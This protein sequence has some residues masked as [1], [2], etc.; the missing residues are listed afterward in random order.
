MIKYV[1]NIHTI[2]DFHLGKV[3][4]SRKK[5]MSGFV[6]SMLKNRSVKF[7]DIASDLNESAQESS[8][9]RRIQ[10]FFADFEMD[11]LLYARMLMQ[12]VPMRRVAISI[13]RTNWKFGDTDINI[14][15]LT[16][17]YQGVGI[18]ILF[19]LLD[20]KGN[21]NSD[22]RCELMDKFVA[23]F[24]A[25]RICS[26]TAD[27]EF[28]GDMWFDY[29]IDKKIPFFLRLKKSHRLTLGGIHYRIDDIINSYVKKGEKYLRNITLHGR[30]PLSIGLRKLL[31]NGKNRQEDDYL[32]I[33]TNDLE[34]NALQEYKKRWS[35]ETFFQSI[36]E[37]GF[38]MEQ[39]HLKEPERL[40][41][42]FAF[43]ALGFV[44][45]VTIGVH[46][47]ESVKEIEVKNHGYK[48]NSFFRVGLDKFRKA[49][50]HVFD[51]ISIINRLITI[52]FKQIEKYFLITF[53][54]K[55]IIT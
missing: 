44:L 35:I 13:D 55:K 4:L 27:R 38:D 32:A 49:L 46:H 23:L 21:S 30:Y 5:F 52:V 10:S 48:Q 31:K 16:V 26:L 36:K 1:I 40:K 43:V 14:L 53:A 19:E 17:H 22:E 11:Y 25:E 47:N 20:K 45:S 54:N 42:L 2:L 15:C 29:L 12:F 34:S 50:N 41:K 33:L 7:S 39:T 8:N 18:P 37:R 24:G 6:L 9:H 28:V 3:H 51:D